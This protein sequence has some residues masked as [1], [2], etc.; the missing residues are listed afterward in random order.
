MRSLL[1]LATAALLLPAIPA[2]PPQAEERDN[3]T[4]ACRKTK[5]AVLYVSN[6]FFLWI[7]CVS[8]RFDNCQSFLTIYIELMMSCLKRRWHC[9]HLCSSMFCPSTYRALF[10]FS[11]KH[12]II[13]RSTIS[14]SWSTMVRLVGGSSTRPLARSLGATRDI[15]WSWAPIGMRRCQCLP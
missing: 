3:D 4:G 5:V 6:I 13:T 2:S 15:R 11:S 14:L 8:V 7:V 9:W 10:N 12:C 1:F